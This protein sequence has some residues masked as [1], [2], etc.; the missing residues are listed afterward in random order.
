MF[1]VREWFSGKSRFQMRWTTR[2]IGLAVILAPVYGADIAYR[3]ASI[4][5]LKIHVQEKHKVIIPAGLNRGGTHWEIT[6]DKGTFH[7]RNGFLFPPSGGADA[8]ADRISKGQ[9]VVLTIAPAGL[10][11]WQAPSILDL[12]KP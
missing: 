9:T 3:Q 12:A 4:H 11:F 8:L 2:T 1:G 7:I 5:D 10:F 6:T